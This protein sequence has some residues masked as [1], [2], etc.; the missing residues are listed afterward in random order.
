VE[1]VSSPEVLEKGWDLKVESARL[2]EILD[3]SLK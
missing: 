1:F 2:K 3:E